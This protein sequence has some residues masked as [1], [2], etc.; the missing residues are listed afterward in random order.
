MR[1]QAT[2]LVRADATKDAYGAV[3][4]GFT[5][6]DTVWASFHTP[7]ERTRRRWERYDSPID[8]AITLA[9]HT[10]CVAGNRLTLGGIVY[11]I[12]GIDPT[13]AEQI[14]A[15]LRQVI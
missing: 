4:E 13:S 9:P 11:E 15:D 14:T 3:R 5:P 2:F 1:N 10:S 7:T 6:G 8:A 12:A